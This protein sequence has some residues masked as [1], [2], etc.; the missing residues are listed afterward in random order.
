MN[1][2]RA[3]IVGAIVAAVFEITASYFEVPPDRLQARLPRARKLLLWNASASA[4]RG[5]YWLS[6]PEPLTIDELVTVVPA[7]ALADFMNIRG[8]LPVGVPLLK[9][10]AAV[11]GQSVCRWQSD[12][13]IDGVWAAQARLRD[14]EGRILPIWVGCRTLRAGEVFLLN[15]VNPDSFDGRYFGVV[16]EDEITARA[17]PLWTLAEP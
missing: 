9:Y 4:P 6:A 12:I 15:P 7:T 3:A 14:S 5:V 10:I 11:G 1:D 16:P 13:A 17:T 8:Y 2:N